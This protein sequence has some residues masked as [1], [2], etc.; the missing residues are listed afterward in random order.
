MHGMTIN[1]IVSID[2]GSRGQKEISEK[3]WRIELVSNMPCGN[4]ENK[5]SFLSVGGFKPSE[6]Y[7]PH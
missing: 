2:H 5:D 7:A 4:H 1:H 6:K 3:G